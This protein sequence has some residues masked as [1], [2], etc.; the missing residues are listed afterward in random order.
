MRAQRRCI[1]EVGGNA[2]A[3]PANPGGGSQGWVFWKPLRVIF[4]SRHQD[5]QN[6]PSPLVGEGGRGMRGTSARECRKSLISPK[7]STLEVELH[8]HLRH[9]GRASVE[10]RIPASSI[11]HTIRHRH[12]RPQF[13]ADH[14]SAYFVDVRGCYTIPAPHPRQ[15]GNRRRCSQP[16]SGRN[17]RFA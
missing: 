9:R 5:V 17:T 1:Q 11:F 7:K 8:V 2:G 6:P 16:H 3:T 15:C 4:R 12:R 10:L 13:R 14:S